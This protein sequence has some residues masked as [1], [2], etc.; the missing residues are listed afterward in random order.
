MRAA[1]AQGQVVAE[2]LLQAVHPHRVPS[3][4]AQLLARKQRAIA[5]LALELAGIEPIIPYLLEP[6]VGDVH[7]D[8]PHEGEGWLGDILP[9]DLLAFVP[10]VVVLVGVVIPRD[11]AF[12]DV[13]SR[14]PPLGYRRVRGVS[15]YVVGQLRYVL[16][17]GSLI[18]ELPAIDVW[19]EGYYVSTVGLNKQT[20]ANYIK[21]Q[22]LEDQIEDRR[23]LKEYKD[24]FTGK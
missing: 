23:S 5:H 7:D 8:P 15:R 24:P 3:H 11:G 1:F 22:E 12:T 9:P 2:C 6:L 17:G 16:G 21:N 14:Y 19:S 4:P 10:D 20:V 13:A 18:G